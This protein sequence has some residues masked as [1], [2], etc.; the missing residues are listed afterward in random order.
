MFRCWPFGDRKPSLL[1]LTAAVLTLIAEHPRFRVIWVDFRVRQTLCAQCEAGWLV[2]SERRSKYNVIFSFSSEWRFR[3]CRMTDWLHILGAA[4]NLY[5]FRAAF[6]LFFVYV[7]RKV[8]RVAVPNCS[9]TVASLRDDSCQQDITLPT[10]KL[11]QTTQNRAGNTIKIRRARVKLSNF[12]FYLLS[13]WATEYRDAD[14]S[15]RVTATESLWN[16][17]I[18]NYR[19]VAYCFRYN[20]SSIRTKNASSKQRWQKRQQQQQ[21]HQQ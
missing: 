15:Y 13:F 18:A 8:Q 1:A 5:I 2:A 3:L 20:V 12:V 11:Q 6:R 17:E 14:C 16:Q 10:Q 19:A 4:T 7:Q 21:Q 9:D